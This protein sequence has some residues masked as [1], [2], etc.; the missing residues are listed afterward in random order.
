M[1]QTSLQWMKHHCGC[2]NSYILIYV[3]VQCLLQYKQFNIHFLLPGAFQQRGISQGS[4]W[5]HAYLRIYRDCL[6]LEKVVKHPNRMPKC[7]ERSTC[8]ACKFLPQKNI[9]YLLCGILGL[10]FWLKLGLMKSFGLFFLYR[11]ILR[12]TTSVCYLSWLLLHAIQ[13]YLKARMWG[14]SLQGWKKLREHR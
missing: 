5:Y 8:H 7:W 6:I 1:T 2:Y 3:H 13:P 9:T 12:R 4:L 14:T 10:K 11:Y